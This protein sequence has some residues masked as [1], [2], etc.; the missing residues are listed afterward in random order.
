MAKTATKP[1]KQATKPPAR[2]PGRKRPA[3]KAW[4]QRV[5]LQSWGVIAAIV[6]VAAFAL[7]SGGEDRPEGP[8]SLP[9]VGA[10]LHSLAVD[11]QD[12]SRLFIG[13]HSGVSVTDDGGKTWRV[14]DSLNG[15]DAMGWAF[16]GDSILVGGHPG[17]YESRDGGKTFEQRNDGLPATDIHALGASG[18]IVY[19]ASPGAGLLVSDDAGESWQIASEDSGQGFMGGILVDPDDPQHLVAPDMSAGAVESTDGG[20][21]W[22][23]LGGVQGA[24]W[25]S[26]DPRDVQRMVVAGMG[27]AA[28][29]ADGGKTWDALEAPSGASIVEFSPNDPD[30]LY[31]AV[32]E[33]PNARVF[34]SRDG[35]QQWDEL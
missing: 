28:I 20:R 2:K 1:R 24:A 21:T 19:A 14:V 29:S 3:P 27:S 18:D 9:V 8:A 4:Y 22:S 23:T 35:G 30:I 26:W 12:P 15:A 6:A 32:L 10:D 13:S 7:L 33:D 5:G 31:A 34:V 16:A 25:V 17:I 11:P